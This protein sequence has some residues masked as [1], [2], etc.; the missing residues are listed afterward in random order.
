MP[1]RPPFQHLLNFLIAS[2]L[3][4]IGLV[5]SLLDFVNLPLIKFY[6]CAGSCSRDTHLL[7]RPEPNRH[8]L[9]YS[10]L[11]HGHAVEHGGDAHGSLAVRDQDELGLHA[12]L[13]H[14]VGEARDVGFVQRSVDFVE[15][16]EWTGWVLEDSY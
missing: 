3:A 11:L 1:T 10:R 16:A 8:Q 4:P 9:R 12:H 7:R 15:N 14:Q 13:T 6:G 2:K 5:Q